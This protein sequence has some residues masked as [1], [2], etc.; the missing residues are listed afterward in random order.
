MGTRYA[1]FV[2]C[3]AFLFVL[4]MLQ[5]WGN[6]S[7]GY[8]DSSRICRAAVHSG[9]VSNAASRAGPFFVEL[10]VLAGSSK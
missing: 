3:G 10:K 4:F 9:V 1:D 6:N 2:L 8:S 5:V 7:A